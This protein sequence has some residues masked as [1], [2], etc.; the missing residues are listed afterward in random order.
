[1]SLG[2]APGYQDLLTPWNHVPDLATPNV[3]GFR[4][5][6]YKMKF[7]KG[8]NQMVTG[9]TIKSINCQNEADKRRLL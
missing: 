6:S 4:S 2:S 3:G 1:M 5:G 7:D 8:I 9:K